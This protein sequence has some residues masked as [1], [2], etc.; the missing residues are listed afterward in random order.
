MIIPT[1]DQITERL[2]QTFLENPAELGSAE[3]LDWRAGFRSG[4]LAHPLNSD[5]I[6]AGIEGWTAGN[7]WLMSIRQSV[8]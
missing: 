6:P 4:A 2:S 1:K 8:K 7:E 5:W 3:Y